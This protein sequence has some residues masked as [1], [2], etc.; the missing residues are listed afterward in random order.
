MPSRRV[1][2]LLISVVVAFTGVF[3]G[4]ASAARHKPRPHTMRLPSP[5]WLTDSLRAQIVA[6]APKPSDGP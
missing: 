5:S 4:T 1:V 3:A 6:Q 2:L